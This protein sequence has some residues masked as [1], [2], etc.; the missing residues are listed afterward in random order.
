MRPSDGLLYV[1]DLRNDWNRLKLQW[2]IKA[3]TDFVQIG[4][5]HLLQGRDDL[6]AVICTTI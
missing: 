3:V 1:L 6:T 2:I 4:E 5:H